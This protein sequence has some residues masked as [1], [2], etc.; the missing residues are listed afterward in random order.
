MTMGCRYPNTCNFHSGYNRGELSLQAV[1]I[2]T[3]KE[4]NMWDEDDEAPESGDS[5]GDGPTDVSSGDGDDSEGQDD[6]YD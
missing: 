3:R 2:T 1:W 6:G 5:D 4:Y